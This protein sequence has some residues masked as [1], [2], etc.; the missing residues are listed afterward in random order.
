MNPRAGAVEY[1]VSIGFKCIA[2]LLSA[3]GRQEPRARARVEARAA[4][5]GETVR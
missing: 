1:T 5:A 2:G 4:A 3:T